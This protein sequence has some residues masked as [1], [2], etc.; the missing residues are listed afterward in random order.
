MEEIKSQMYK[1]NDVLIDSEKVYQI[2][3]FQRDFVWGEEQVNELFDDFS[4]DT[5]EFTKSND[6]LQGYL[7]GNIVLIDYNNKYMVID[8]QQRLTTLTLLFKALYQTLYLRIDKSSGKIRD[9]WMQKIGSIDNAYQIKDDEDNFKGLRLIHDEG[10]SFGNYYKDLIR[11][12]QI[13]EYNLLKNSDQKISEVFDTLTEKIGNLNDD[14]LKKFINYI[15]NKV[16]LIVTIA[17]SEGKAFQLFEVL[18]DRGRSL[19]PMDLVKNTF[20][21]QL[22]MSGFNDNDTQT[23]NNNWSEF[24]NNLIITRKQK[25]SSS[26]F[27][28]HFVSSQYAKNVKQDKLFDFFK[29]K[30]DLNGNIIFELSHKLK[31]YSAVY[32]SIEK[33]PLDNDYIKDDNNLY[34][35]FKLLKIKQLHPILMLFYNSNEEIKRNVNDL[36]VKYAATIV[37]SSTQTNSIEKELPNII[38]NLLKIND[39]YE[40]VKKLEGLI[41]K[42]IDNYSEILV[43]SLTNKVYANSSGKPLN[44][45]MVILQFI[46]LYYNENNL[47]IKTNR[48][49][50]VTLEH[51]LA[52]KTKLLSLSEYGFTEKDEM[53]RYI[54]KIGNLTL[55]YNDEN[56]SAGIEDISK[57]KYIYENSDFIITKTMVKNLETGIKNGKE[58]ERIKKI[59]RLEPVYDLNGKWTKEKIEQRSSNISK[60]ILEAVKI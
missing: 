51:I 5:A 38:D 1:L 17:P 13:I 53:D 3:E 37:F 41:S 55:L 18:N 40:K 2:P 28:K 27:M 14:Q 36:C 35:I 24:L 22:R 45:A 56:T 26:T 16:K 29:E 8:G 10:L 34:I 46:E 12:T 47:I 11:D 7:L 31:N 43:N 23:F 20:L 4:E 19:E 42:Q 33:N 48:S 57:K 6:E 30:D 52:R 59:N 54:N 50:K 15:K 60:I 39:D 44:K 49:K 25:I 58:T 9:Q 21:K 32:S